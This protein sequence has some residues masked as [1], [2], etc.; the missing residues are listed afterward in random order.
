MK[1]STALKNEVIILSLVR[2][3]PFFTPMAQ[4]SWG[5]SVLGEAKKF[6]MYGDLKN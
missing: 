3:C 2:T 1:P 6:I 5:M 4:S